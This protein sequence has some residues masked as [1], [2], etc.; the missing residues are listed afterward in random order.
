[1]SIFVNTGFK[2]TGDTT[3]MHKIRDLKYLSFYFQNGGRGCNQCTSGY[4]SIY[5]ANVNNDVKNYPVINGI[6]DGTASNENKYI[7]TKTDIGT[8][9]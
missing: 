7:W 5:R 6:I 3:T 1:M 2:I 8:N 9:R 4:V